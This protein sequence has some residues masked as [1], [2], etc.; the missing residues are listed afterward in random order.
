MAVVEAVDT[1]E[2]HTELVDV[3]V[4]PEENGGG[5]QGVEG[6]DLRQNPWKAGPMQFALSELL[7]DRAEKW[8]MVNGLYT[9]AN[10]VLTLLRC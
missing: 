4:E 5:R 7:V 1:L 3:P 10:Q 6:F 2:S 8:E 9:K